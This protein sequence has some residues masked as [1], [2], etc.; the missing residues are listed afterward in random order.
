MKKITGLFVSL[1]IAVVS[2]GQTNVV[3]P[4]L[5]YGVL[6][7]DVQMA[8]IFPDN[9]TF[10]DCTPKR[11]PKDIVKDYLAL[12]NNPRV[13]FS[14][15]L[16]VEE[17]F[18]IPGS[19][20]GAYQ[21]SDTNIVSHIN[22]LWK[23]LQRK[24]DKPVEGSTLLSLPHPYIVPGGRFRE[25]YYWDSYF[26]MLGLKES[27]EME[28]IE[29]MIKNFAYMIQQYGHIPN[30]NRNYYLT[31]SQPP[32]FS[33]MVELLASIKGESVYKTFLPALEK[34]YAYWMEGSAKLKPGQSFK[35]VVKMKDGTVLNRYWDDA[36]TPRQE[37]YYQDVET[38]WKLA[39]RWEQTDSNPPLSELSK[40]KGRELLY[41]NLR[42]A[43]ASGWDFSS[44]WFKDGENLYSIQTTSIIPV[45]LHSLLFHLEKT[46]EKA[47]RVA[48]KEKQRKQLSV[49]SMKRETA[50]PKFFSKEIDF[51]TDINFVTGKHTN[52]ITAASLFPLSFFIY[53]HPDGQSTRGAKA[54]TF[55]RKHLLRDGGIVTTP[56]KS[57][58]Q[59]DAPNGWAPLQW[60]AVRG[61]YQSGEKE[62]ATDI[63]KRWMLLNEKTFTET[64]KLMEKYNVEDITKP[65]GGG[66][67]DGQD[68]FGWTNGV[69]LAMKKMLEQGK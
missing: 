52:T 56:K 58:Q 6:F 5:V 19:I 3:P 53:G 15:K 39:E 1:I 27:G 18:I 40:K 11:S 50:L 34:E 48:G 36:I 7:E 24:P 26:T 12:K 54:A 45:D 67:Y 2:T 37:S 29:N 17:N 20:T 57:S 10:V 38:F 16:F 61:L 23:V 21:T 68:G 31:R 63:A 14:L 42:A 32:F 66:E 4:D 33:S 43:A 60:I 30:G 35:R 51:Y 28:M 41:T 65:A 64:G 25:I 47:Y 13:K 49:L 22:N 59:W 46:L 44:R 55:I 69:Y 9:K 62:L 8:R